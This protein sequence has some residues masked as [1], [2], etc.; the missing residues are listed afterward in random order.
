MQRVWQE[1][2]E[3]HPPLVIATAVDERLLAY[4]SRGGSVLFL[5]QGEGPL[6][7]RRL[8]FWRESIKLFYPHAVWERFPHEG[9][10]DLQF[11]GLATDVALDSERLR[12]LLPH[13]SS[14]KPILRRL[15]AREFHISDHLVELQAGRGRMLVSTLRHQ[16]GAGA[17][18]TGL[19]RNVAGYALLDAL[20]RYLLR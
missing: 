10:A 4:L 7:M 6:P 16:G 5:Q 13:I 20:V 19:E 18:P 14:I 17:Q 11:Y 8:P 1:A 3:Q 12:A 9:F 15:D 2:G